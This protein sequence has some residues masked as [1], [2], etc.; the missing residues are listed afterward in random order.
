MNKA[1][2]VGLVATN[3]DVTQ[4]DAAR[5]MDAFTEAIM[6]TV[7]NGQKVTLIGFGTFEVHL[8]TE[9]EGRNPATGK[10]LTIP[11]KMRPKFRPGREFKAQ[12]GG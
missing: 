12:V 6:S 1:E 9:R 8:S 2:L 11:A 3:A 4:K 7:A 5:V 10:A